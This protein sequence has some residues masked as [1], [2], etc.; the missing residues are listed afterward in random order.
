LHV[1]APEAVRGHFE[2]E[3]MKQKIKQNENIPSA[4]FFSI[5]L[6]FGVVGAYFNPN[7]FNRNHNVLQ[8]CF[9]QMTVCAG[10]L[11]S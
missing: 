7:Y 3:E 6:R 4:S 5:P 9:K 8:G 11:Q 10:L 2:N 1:L